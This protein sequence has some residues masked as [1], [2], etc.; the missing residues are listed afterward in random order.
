MGGSGTAKRSY[1][2]FVPPLPPRSLKSAGTRQLLIE[3][4]RRQFVARGYSAVSMRDIAIAAELTTGAVYGHFR[5]KGQLLVEVIR[6][7]MAAQDETIDYRDA[8]TDPARGVEL[9]HNQIGRDLRALEVDAAAA[10]RHDPEIAAGLVSLYTERHE[11]IRAVVA[12]LD[13]PD[14]AA[15][16]I[17]AL[18]GGIGM[19]E[20]TGLRSPDDDRLN[21]ALLGVVNGL[22]AA[23]SAGEHT[24]ESR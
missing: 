14:T 15:W 5:S 16:I 3:L 1:P 6:W 18:T 12:E 9:M 20:S 17:A 13:D 8:A 11:R 7:T 23:R 4:A 24:G 21:A 19:K 22:M 10:A 2:T